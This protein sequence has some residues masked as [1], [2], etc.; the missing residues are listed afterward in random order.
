MT[1]SLG[2]NGNI[3]LQEAARIAGCSTSTIWNLVKAGKIK[4]QKINGQWWVVHADVERVKP[5]IRPRIRKEVK[6][7]KEKI[8]GP[9][10]VDLKFSLD[11]Q[12]LQILSLVCEVNGSTLT[13][14][15]MTKLEELYDKTMENLKFCKRE[16]A[17]TNQNSDE[18]SGP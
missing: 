18:V 3:D 6:E 16:Y 17:R 9:D 13:G 7:V 8:M 4:G 11:K 5:D 1:V 10:L 2:L 12:K 14:F 15:V